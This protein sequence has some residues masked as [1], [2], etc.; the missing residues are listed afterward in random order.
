MSPR[1]LSHL[2]HIFFL[3]TLVFPVP[4]VRGEVPGG[5]FGVE[6]RRLQTRVGQLERLVQPAVAHAP[7]QDP[8][9]Q[10]QIR[11][12]RPGAAG[13]MRPR[14][15]LDLDQNRRITDLGPTGSGNDGVL[16]LG[17][18]SLEED[19]PWDW[20]RA[21]DTNL[22]SRLDHQDYGF[23]SLQIWIDAN[24]DLIPRRDEMHSPSSLGIQRI[25]IPE[26]PGEDQSH[27][28]SVD[29]GTHLAGL[30]EY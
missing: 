6:L 2:P 10:E 21:Y 23:E 30:T 20:V 15:S 16:V 17:V 29:G 4:A 24:R 5:P 27:W 19:S 12:V 14:I 9:I 28:E 3:L 25:V 13:P 1:P 22:D 8:E 26:V 7:E 18:A 11:L